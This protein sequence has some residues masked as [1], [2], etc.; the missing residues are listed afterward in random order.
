MKYI[1]NL[2]LGGLE[3][4]LV[5]I[6]NK[7]FYLAGLCTLPPPPITFTGTQGYLY[8]KSKLGYVNKKEDWWGLW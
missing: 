8:L 6:L 3:L 5:D 7:N 4:S 2:V 1:F